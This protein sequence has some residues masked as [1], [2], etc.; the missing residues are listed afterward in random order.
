MERKAEI[1]K[2]LE[3]KSELQAALFKK[4]LGEL[5]IPARVL[6]QK[7]EKML[8][9]NQEGGVRPPLFIV[10]AELLLSKAKKS[11]E[12]PETLQGV[13]PGTVPYLDRKRE[14]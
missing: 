11:S 4:E 12:S 9:P 2:A 14:I 7:F 1:T 5:A 10:M 13:L 3:Y 6:L 8:D